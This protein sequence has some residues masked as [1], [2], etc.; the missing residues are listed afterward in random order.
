MVFS[1]RSLSMP[2]KS[3]KNER[4]SWTPELLIPCSLCDYL[5]LSV[6]NGRVCIRSDF[7][8]KHRKCS[9]NFFSWIFW[10]RFFYHFFSICLRKMKRAKIWGKGYWNFTFKISNQMWNIIVLCGA[11]FFCIFFS[12]F[13]SIQYLK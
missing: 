2:L 5:C 10:N 13:L 4:H 3:D 6:V 12:V 1:F 8:K 9:V 7:H 11:N